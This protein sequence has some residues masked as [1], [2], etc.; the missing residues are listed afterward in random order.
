MPNMSKNNGDDKRPPDTASLGERS[1]DHRERRREERHAEMLGVQEK[2]VQ[3][4]KS[5]S[6]ATWLYGIMAGLTLFWLVV[7]FFLNVLYF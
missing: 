6:R 5:I 7:M 3:A 2:I 1:R 4:T